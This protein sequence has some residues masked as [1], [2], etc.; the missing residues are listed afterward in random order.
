MYIGERVKI[1]NIDNLGNKNIKYGDTGRIIAYE[2]DSL[3]GVTLGVE[4]DR[5]IKG[6]SCNGSGENGYCAWVRKK[7][8]V[9]INS[10]KINIKAV[11]DLIVDF[12]CRNSDDGNWIV[13]YLDLQGRISEDDFKLYIKEITDEINKNDKVADAKNLGHEIDVVVWL[14]YLEKDN[15]FKVE[16]DFNKETYE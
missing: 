6:H 15:P 11:A 1:I 3:V 13:D 12:V 14:N 2:Y 9:K 7:K 16:I 4:F 8:L 5:Y 10:P